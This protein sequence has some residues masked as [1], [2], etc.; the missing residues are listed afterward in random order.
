[1]HLPMNSLHVTRLGLHACLLPPPRFRG[2]RDPRQVS[3]GSALFPAAKR[4]FLAILARL[5]FVL[6]S[7]PPLSYSVCSIYYCT[8]DAVDDLPP[9][10][11]A[12]TPSIHLVSQVA[13]WYTAA[14]S[15]SPVA[16]P[17]I[18]M[19][20]ENFNNKNWLW[21]KQSYVERLFLL[22]LITSTLNC[23]KH[24]QLNQLLSTITYD[25]YYF[26]T[27]S[28]FQLIW[29]FSPEIQ[30]TLFGDLGSSRLRIS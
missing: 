28:Y 12:P 3:R 21:V 18:A 25:Q 5:S 30:V 29:K 15:V 13:S 16:Y 26:C 27:L 17:L 7:P 4:A 8:G 14:N 19:N 23:V 11:S 1:M 6:C 10:P 2:T 9:V 24:Y 20:Y 22:S